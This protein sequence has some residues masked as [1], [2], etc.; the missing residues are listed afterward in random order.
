MT[1]VING[2]EKKIFVLASIKD[3][4]NDLKYLKL[5]FEE[6]KRSIIN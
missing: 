1:E 6:F 2:L 3:V 4:K 5:S